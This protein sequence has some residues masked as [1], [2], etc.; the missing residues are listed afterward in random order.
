MNAEY[1]ELSEL[2]RQLLEAIID[3]HSLGAVLS[4]LS[5]ICGKKAE[6]IA[7]HWQDMK[8]SKQWMKQ[9]VILDRAH[10]DVEAL[11]G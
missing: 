10:R 11:G 3:V 5:F 1:R 2:D 4:A 7:T 9:T 6:H 8:L